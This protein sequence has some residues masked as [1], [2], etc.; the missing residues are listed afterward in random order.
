MKMFLTYVTY[1]LL[2]NFITVSSFRRNFIFRIMRPKHKKH[3][4]FIDHFWKR[5]DLNNYSRLERERAAKAA[6]NE[7]QLQCLD[8]QTLL[9]AMRDRGITSSSGYRP[10]PLTGGTSSP[11]S[12]SLDLEWEHEYAAN[13]SWYFIN[14]FNFAFK[15]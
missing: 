8:A 13:Q 1:F 2:F 15:F 14:F 10:E 5:K 6:R 12:S 3:S 4:K 7:I 11:A 9:V